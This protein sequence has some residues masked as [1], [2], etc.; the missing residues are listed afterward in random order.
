MAVTDRQ[1]A[2]QPRLRSW[3]STFTKRARLF[4]DQ[5][6][7]WLESN[8]LAFLLLFSI[9]YL[10]GAGLIASH[11]FLW[12]DEV[13]TAYINR[14]SLPQLLPALR[15]GVDLQPPLFHLITRAFTGV[16]G[17]TPLALR[18]P[19][20]I[21]G[22][23]MCLSLYIFASRR[24]RPLY[25]AI[26][27][28]IP[29]ITESARYTYEARSYGIALGFSGMAL[30]SWQ[31]AAERR[32]VVSPMLL[33]LSLASAIACH[34]YMVLVLVAIGAGEAV[35]SFSR[36]RIE[37]PIWAALA[38]SVLP[39]PLHAAMIRAALTFRGGNWSTANAVALERAYM[40]FLA[41]V[42]LPVAVVVTGLALY[43]S[44]A[45][46]AAT[47]ARATQRGELRPW[48]M[49]AAMVLASSFAGVW[50]IARLTHG[51]FTPRYGLCM[52]FG[53]AILALP[54]IRAYDTVR[55]LASALVLFALIGSYPMRQI[56]DHRGSYHTP[57]LLRKVDQ[58]RAIVIE[59]PLDF[60]ELIYNEPPQL[61]SRLYYLPSSED[62][63]RYKGTDD[64]DRGLLLLSRWFPLRVEDPDLF[65]KHNDRILIW[66]GSKEPQWF[67]RKLVDDGATISLAGAL[68][69]QQL[70]VATSHPD[71]Q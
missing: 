36:R 56:L 65:L 67:L 44:V 51:I 70:F 41:P 21:G 39:L 61:A 15:S 64:D 59:N 16:L 54:A 52:I 13:L 6:A 19:A 60:L 4:P 1:L 14:L 34:F 3:L 43:W 49:V 32:R 33:A 18:L 55:P 24:F 40:N 69:D 28:I 2:F 47:Q 9:A 58:S 25:G 22:W 31:S 45:P 7:E 38:A 23:M 48:E 20:I 35:R 71:V 10:F 53:I 57:A 17:P 30:V 12:A 29:L 27:M 66:Q 37:V 46:P 50:I 62:A 8:R 63:I 42:V 5:V 11:R 26:A 68:S